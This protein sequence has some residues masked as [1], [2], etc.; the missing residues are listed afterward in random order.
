[1]SHPSVFLINFF[2]NFNSNP[3]VQISAIENGAIQSMLRILSTELSFT[4]RKKTMYALS[5]LLRHFP[6]AQKKFLELGGLASLKKLFQDNGIEAEQLQVRAVTLMYDLVTEKV[7]KT[8]FYLYR[9]IFSVS[10]YFWVEY[11][12][13]KQ[14]FI[15]HLSWP[16]QLFLLHSPLCLP[17]RRLAKTNSHTSDS[18]SGHVISTS[19]ILF[20]LT[21][22]MC[23]GF[24]SLRSIPVSQSLCL[25]SLS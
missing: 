14:A 9:C 11:S 4:V 2:L 19:F 23:F 7:R 3:K 13:L 22:W 20:A 17:S 24:S 18:C 15:F 5:S 1:M 12:S 21:V 8:M 6:Y 25:F 16:L 10:I